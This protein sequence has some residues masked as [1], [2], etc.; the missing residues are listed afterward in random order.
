MDS[1]MAIKTIERNAA[2]APS[3]RLHQQM[4]R[5]HCHGKK[6]E[7]KVT[8]KINDMTAA[9]TRK[10]VRRDG[11]RLCWHCVNYPR[12]GFDWTTLPM[13]QHCDDDEDPMSLSVISVQNLDKQSLLT[14]K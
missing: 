12:I 6:R 7:N 10:Q 3:R 11:S 4:T 5:A 1:R 2:A 9:V 13:E 14:N 8:L